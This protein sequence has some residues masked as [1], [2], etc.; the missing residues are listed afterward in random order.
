MAA[1]VRLYHG[2]DGKNAESILLAGLRASTQGKLG[3]GVYFTPDLNA[4]NKIAGYRGLPFVIS[5]DVVVGRQYDY[6][7]NPLNLP[8]VDGSWRNHGFESAQAT[9]P[10][11]AGV[12]YPFPEVCVLNPGAATMVEVHGLIIDRHDKCKGCA[13]HRGCT[14]PGC[15]G[16]QFCVSA[17]PICPDAVCAKGGVGFP[18][19]SITGPGGT[20]GVWGTVVSDAGD[21]WVFANGRIAKKAN[22]GF[23][24]AWHPVGVGYSIEGI[25][26]AG[27]SSGVWGKVVSDAGDKWMFGNGR[28]AKK[29]NCGLVWRWL[30]A[31]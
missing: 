20:P 6:D 31:V 24:W 15:V 4:A 25:D 26:G 30:V 28:H 10:P 8:M 9:H 22:E 12:T 27:G 2:T 13:N 21:K 29:A 14:N 5:C 23:V 11:W 1:T 3:A 16:K 19:Q 7:S 17:C 18:I